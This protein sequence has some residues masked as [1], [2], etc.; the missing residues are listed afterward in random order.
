MSAPLKIQGM[1]GSA[2][3]K[4]PPE[5]IP[6][7]AWHRTRQPRVTVVTRLARSG[8]VSEQQA[9]RFIG[10]ANEPI[11]R[12]YQRL[13]T[14]DLKACLDAVLVGEDKLQSSQNPDALPAT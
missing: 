10:H 6:P 8:K 11:H 13:R 3:E 9:M 4:L 5:R 14:S 12:I 7:A 1:E 2:R